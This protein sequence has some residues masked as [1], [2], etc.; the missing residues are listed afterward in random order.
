MRT[1][2]MA[3]TAARSRT[4]VKETAVPIRSRRALLAAAAI[5]LAAVSSPV[6]AG[7]RPVTAEELRQ[8]EAVLR[9]EGFV[10]WGEVEFDDGRFEVDDAIAADGRK[11]DLKL[12]GVDFTIQER[13]LDD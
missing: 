10:R 8:I 5:T 2:T 11:Y 12:S 13:E 6:R 3:G 4:N 9:R 7:D 1:K